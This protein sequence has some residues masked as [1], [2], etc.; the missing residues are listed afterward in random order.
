MQLLEAKANVNLPFAS[1]APPLTVAAQ[2]ADADACRLLLRAAADVSATV[3]DDNQL[4]RSALS[5]A[6]ELC[7][8]ECVGVLLDAKA[9][10]QVGR[11]NCLLVAASHGHLRVI[12]VRVAL[13]A[14]FPSASCA[15][16]VAV[17]GQWR[18][19]AARLRRGETHTAFS[20]RRR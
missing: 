19:C 1:C 9:P 13:V 3:H 14:A 8:T 6:V 5:V 17:V 15:R 11:A 7:H 20:G 16:R 4:V 10:V 18:R 2:F 12:E